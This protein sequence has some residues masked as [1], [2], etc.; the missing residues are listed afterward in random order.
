MNKTLFILFIL[1][2]NFGLGQNLIPNPSFEI[3]DT[4]PNQFSTNFDKQIE[5][6]IGWT[7]PTQYGTSDY[8]N[9]CASTSNPWTKVNVPDAFMGYQ[10]AYDGNGYCGFFGYAVDGDGI[11]GTE[12]IQARLLTPL[13]SGKT[14]NV[15]FYVSLA[16]YSEYAITEIGAYFSVTAISKNVPKPF[17]FIPQI[18]SQTGVY[19][20]DTLNW[21]KIEGN[22]I[23][24]GNEE[25]ITIGNFNDSLDIDTSNTG[26]IFPTGENAAYYYIDGI[27]IEEVAHA[28]VIPN[29]ITPNGDGSNDIFQLNFQYESVIIYNRWGQSL[30]ESNNNESYWNGRTTSGSEVPDGTYYYLITTKEETFKGFVQVIRGNSINYK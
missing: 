26:I 16:N 10:N 4:C 12:Y 28:V 2:S 11:F 5:H 7:F 14:Y 17:S 21:M 9:S 30:F 22:F 6:C 13:N 24:Q 8:F 23:A 15:V 27:S 29:I 3:Y 18:V 19:L 25:Y 20:S 1:I